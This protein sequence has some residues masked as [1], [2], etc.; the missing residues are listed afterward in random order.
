MGNYEWNNS[1]GEGTL[2]NLWYYYADQ[3]M[4]HI[5]SAYTYTNFTD[6]S[7]NYIYYCTILEA[8]TNSSSPENLSSCFVQTYRRFANVEEYK[9]LRLVGY[10]R[11]EVTSNNAVPSRTILLVKIRL[12]IRHR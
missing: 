5:G 12:G 8:G 9:M 11:S 1:S 3:K 7:P 10:K 6:P 4:Q 2:I